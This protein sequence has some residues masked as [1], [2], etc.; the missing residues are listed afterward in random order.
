MRGSSCYVRSPARDELRHVID[1]DSLGDTL[2]DALPT[3]EMIGRIRMRLTIL[4]ITTTTAV[5]TYLRGI[6]RMMIKTSPGR[7]QSCLLLLTDNIVAVVV[8]IH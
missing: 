3:N 6:Y 4:M 5:I 8:I 2:M 1:D 7:I